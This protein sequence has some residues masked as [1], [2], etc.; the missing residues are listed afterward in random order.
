MILN[1]TF[2]N[3]YLRSYYAFF[4]WKKAP[5]T[6]VAF[7]GGDSPQRKHRTSGPFT[8]PLGR[9]NRSSPPTAA[10]QQISKK[11]V[12]QKTK[13]GVLTVLKPVTIVLKPVVNVVD[14]ILSFDTV[15]IKKRQ[16]YL[17][18]QRVK[19]AESFDQRVLES[20]GTINQL[21]LTQTSAKSV[22]LKSVAG[23]RESSAKS[24]PLVTLGKRKSTTSVVSQSHY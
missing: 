1:N 15:L 7:A 23:P 2:L 21:D 3:H 9:E 5:A 12:F 8:R 16:T 13:T 18:K 20:Q 24:L 17:A 11:T 10:F 14:R 4:L 22:A 19:K 6:P